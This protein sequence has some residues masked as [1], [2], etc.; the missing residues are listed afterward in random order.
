MNVFKRAH[1]IAREL[2]AKVAIYKVRF[3][4]GLKRAYAE[5]KAKKQAKLDAKLDSFKA[6]Y[7]KAVAIF[8]EADKDVQELSEAI[9][10]AQTSGVKNIKTTNRRLAKCQSLCNLL[11]ITA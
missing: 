2:D 11:K 6:A 1:E 5:L 10:W 4:I 8:G 7:K 3:G 9:V